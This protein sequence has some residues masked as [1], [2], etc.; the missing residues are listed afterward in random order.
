MVQHTFLEDCASVPVKWFQRP[1]GARPLAHGR[2]LPL[3]WLRPPATNRGPPGI[4]ATPKKGVIPVCHCNDDRP[5][6]PSKETEV[7]PRKRNWLIAS[8]VTL[9]GVTLSASIVTGAVKPDQATALATVA[10]TTAT[11][12]VLLTR[13]PT[14]V[15]GD[16]PAP[17]LPAG[18]P[19]VDKQSLGTTGDQHEPGDDEDPGP[20][21][22]VPL[23]K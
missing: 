22:G 21:S 20:T 19:P 16:L 11:S 14:N 7:T 17:P 15:T 5:S 3:A 9:A 13:R 10:G 1:D 18:P 6:L 23:A 8:G 2:S 12:V 4:V